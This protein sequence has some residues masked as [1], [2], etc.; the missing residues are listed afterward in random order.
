MRIF[1]KIHHFL[2]YLLILLLPV[3]LGKHFWPN[4]ALVGGIRIDYLSPT[5][6]LTDLLVVGIL[7]NWSISAALKL[8]IK[9][10]NFALFKTSTIRGVLS[11]HLGGEKGKAFFSITNYQLLITAFFSF[12]ILNIFLAQN[13][14]VAVLKAL[15][16][17]ELV[18]LGVYVKNNLTIKPSNNLTI[19]LSITI[20][21][22]SLIAWVQFLK[23]ASIGGLFWWLG[24]R[25]FV[26]STPGIAQ[27][28]LDG[29]L[30][31]RP[32]ATFSHPN[33]LGGYL[34]VT[35]SLIVAN[36]MLI[37]T[38]CLPAGRNYESRLRNILKILAVV[39]GI[40]ALFITFSRTAW[41]VG[42]AGI[43]IS[44]LFS[45]KW[46][47]RR[48][49]GERWLKRENG[50]LL[51]ICLLL[52]VLFLFLGKERLGQLR[53]KSE[54]VWL[55]KELN[56]VALSMIKKH[57]LTGVG[58]NNFIVSLSQFKKGLSFKELQPAHNIYLLIG[59]ETGLLGLGVFMWLIWLSYRKLFQKNIKTLKHKNKRLL[60]TNYQLLITFSAILALGFFDHYFFT[61]QQ[62]QLLFAIVLGMVFGYDKINESNRPN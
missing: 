11:G 10:K 57:P 62:T 24:E 61:L 44:L 31:L 39:L 58:L 40:T 50:L 56:Q 16:I 43:I 25:T 15:K 22:S 29:R 48:E 14:P 38:P 28:V 51:V 37:N 5:I 18:L 9:Y 6:Y 19:L 60:I 4:W 13:R 32:Y 46:L 12:F 45:W 41:I 47:K 8:K 21:Y 20:I 34:A 53:F 33:V 7:V 59:A 26:S 42:G 3:Q 54:S 1:K 17:T 52:F 30:M 49:R 55:R 27:V 36:H 2:F 23:Q 35:L